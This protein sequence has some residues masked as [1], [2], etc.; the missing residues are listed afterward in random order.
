MKNI[1]IIEDE[2]MIG[3]LLVDVLSDIGNISCVEGVDSGISALKKNK[4]DL[5]I[6]DFYLGKSNSIEIF[7]EV[8]PIHPT[9]PI[10]L[11][12]GYPTADMLKSAKELDITI[13]LPKPLNMDMLRDR[14]GLLLPK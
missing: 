3:E 7:K 4:Y 10:I 13:F 8:R 11:M 2:K 1:L 9:T 5:I 12:S 14:I 6:S